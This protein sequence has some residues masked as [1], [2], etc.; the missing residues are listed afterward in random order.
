MDDAVRND[1][2][3]RNSAIPQI[4]SHCR[5]ALRGFV[6][7]DPVFSTDPLPLEA[8]AMLASDLLKQHRLLDKL[9]GLAL[10]MSYGLFTR[11]SETLK[12]FS[13]DVIASQTRCY[14][15][16]S[17]IIAKSGAASDATA[18]QTASSTTPSW[19]ACW[20]SSSNSC[21]CSLNVC[22]PLARLK[23]RSCRHD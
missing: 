23:C 21:G 5:R 4:M 17:V 3:T 6:Q 1:L 10:A 7:G 12:I 19:P 13:R 14:H 18:A 15:S 16:V 20:A 8:M 2:L 22:K 9:A 11:P